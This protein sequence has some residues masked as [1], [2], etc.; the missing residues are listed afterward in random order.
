MRFP[1][2]SLISLYFP[3][4]PPSFISQALRIEL[5]RL[6]TLLMEH[7][8]RELVDHRKELI[9]FAWNHLKSDDSQAKHWAYV[10]ALDTHFFVCCSHAFQESKP[11]KSELA[12]FE[13]HGFPLPLHFFNCHLIP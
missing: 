11:R 6:A 4:L 2:P 5:L 8:G 7:L 3:P 10:S 1:T 9:K 12:S 13:I